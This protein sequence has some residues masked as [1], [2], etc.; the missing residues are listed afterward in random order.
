M[1]F[2]QGFGP[3]WGPVLDERVSAEETR[4][5]LERLAVHEFGG[6]DGTLSAVCEAS[7]AAPEVAGRILADIRGTTWQELFGNR[8]AAMERRLRDHDE[9][10]AYLGEKIGVEPKSQRDRDAEA[11][12]AGLSS[13][14][15][16][17]Q[18]MR[19][20]MWWIAA[21][22]AFALMLTGL[23]V[24]RQG[25]ETPPPLPPVEVDAAAPESELAQFP[26]DE[27]GAAPAEQN[28]R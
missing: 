27:N 1:R 4:L 16:D 18:E 7:G 21:V 13:Q 28:A 14:F 19:T 11:M 26:P 2:E 25:G 8:V 5:L 9:K 22:I 17:Q 3:E 15:A 24:T 6:G 23:L 10:I 12:L 20:R